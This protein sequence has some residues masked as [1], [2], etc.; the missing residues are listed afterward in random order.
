MCSLTHVSTRFRT[1]GPASRDQLRSLL[2]WDSTLR[3]LFQRTRCLQFFAP[4]L[5]LSNA[6]VAFWS[7]LGQN[8]AVI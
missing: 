6:G 7:G 4:A 3:C 8:V 1:H 2:A 5:P